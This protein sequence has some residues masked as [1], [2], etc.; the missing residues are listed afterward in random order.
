MGLEELIE[1]LSKTSIEVFRRNSM[2][3]QLVVQNIHSQ[4]LSAVCSALLGCS[5]QMFGRV[6]HTDAIP[7][8]DLMK[9]SFTVRQH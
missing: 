4:V 2:L 9:L 5:I 6:W 3:C 1:S 8:C 7:N